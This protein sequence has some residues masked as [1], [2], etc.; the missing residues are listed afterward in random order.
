MGLPIANYTSLCRPDSEKTCF[1]CCPPL[2]PHGYDPLQKRSALKPMLRRNRE[3]FLN[4]KQA[5]TGLSPNPI[6][7]WDCWGL[8]YLD[9][10]EQKVGCLLHPSQHSGNDYRYLVEYEGKCAWEICLEAKTFDALGE[11][12]KQFYLDMTI[13]MDSFEYSSREWNPVFTILLWGRMVGEKIAETEG[14]RR[15]HRNELKERYNALFTILSYKTDGYLVEEIVK[16]AGFSCIRKPHFFEHYNKG[17]AGLLLKHRI[18]D[19][20]FPI[21]QKANPSNRPVHLF[22]VPLSFS[23]FLKFALNIWNAPEERVSYLKKEIDREIE[24]FVEN[25]LGGRCRNLG[26]PKRP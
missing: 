1:F 2:R 11:K 13:G 17:K 24:S 9:E 14:F 7:G 25:S 10:G 8:G 19:A 5:S 16:R 15:I 21:T 12:A 18:D 20:S 22:D 26:E 4:T 6:N 3:L 23:R